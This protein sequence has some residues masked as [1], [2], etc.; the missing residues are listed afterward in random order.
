MLAAKPSLSGGYIGALRVEANA[1]YVHCLLC[2]V[3]S[4]KRWAS[5][6]P[7]ASASS[8]SPRPCPP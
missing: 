4:Q 8:T 2:L 7:A 1:R 3:R 5:S 6:C